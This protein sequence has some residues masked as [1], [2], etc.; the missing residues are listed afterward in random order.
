MEDISNK[1]ILALL[2]VA[3]VVTVV[4]TTFSVIKISDLSAPG[5][6][7]ILS[8]AVTQTGTADLGITSTVSFTINDSSV[9]F[10]TGYVNTSVAA[11][12]G[13]YLLS[14]GMGS[15][16]DS[17]NPNGAVIINWVNSSSM[18]DEFIQINNTGTVPLTINVTAGGLN[19]SE[20][21]F[22]ATDNDCSGN[23]FG[24]VEVEGVDSNSVCSGTL[25]DSLGHSYI[26][27]AGDNAQGNQNV[28]LCSSWNTGTNS[29]LNVSL[30]I[31]VPKNA[32]TSISTMTLVFTAI[33]SS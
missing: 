7:F 24:R 30:N 22:C 4:G 1:T 11:T 9:D 26:L 31:S 27:A 33:E 32:E 6:D 2:T 21:W 14:R 15:Y 10:G 3:L 28:T 18:A 23:D 25:N 20:A 13:A 19:N 5:Q 16:I 8:G 17:A 29:I 12:G